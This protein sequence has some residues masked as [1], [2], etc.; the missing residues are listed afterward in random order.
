MGTP[1]IIIVNDCG[2][3]L[4]CICSGDGYLDHT[5]LALQKDFGDKDS[6]LALVKGGD[7]KGLYDTVERF[8]GE[9][10]RTREYTSLESVRA[11]YEFCQR[12]YLFQDSIW[13]V[14][15]HSSLMRLYWYQLDGDK[16][17]LKCAICGFEETV[18]DGNNNFGN[19]ASEV[20]LNNK[21][22]GSVCPNCQSKFTRINHHGDSVIAI[23]KIMADGCSALLPFFL[24]P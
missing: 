2:V 20:F 13:S 16:S 9:H 19:W 11:G 21:N 8:K 23:E 3:Y 5:G 6:A 4:S 12:I 17:E 10:C 22:L 18:I 7:F 1:A 15:D 14:V 24:N